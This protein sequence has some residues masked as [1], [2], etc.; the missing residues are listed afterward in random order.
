MGTLIQSSPDPA[1]NRWLNLAPEALIRIVWQGRRWL[2]W[3]TGS[4]VVMGIFVAL[5][6][7]PEFV[8]EARIMPELSTA[9]G[10]LF[11]RLAS[12]TGFAGL[13]L[14]DAEA[15]DAIRPDLY[16]N[17]LQSTPFLLDLIGRPVTT[18]EGHTTTVGR[19]L[20]PDDAAGWS[21]TRLFAFGR[22][23]AGQPKKTGKRRGPVELTA[24]Q[25]DLV[26]EIGKRVTARLDT[27][28]GIITIRAQMPDARVAALVAQYA[29]DYL[30][31][32]VTTYRTEKARQDLQFYTQRLTEARRRYQTAQYNVF[33]YNDQ[34]KYFV[35]QAATMDKQHLEA[36]LTIA[37]TVYT[38]LS[39]QFEQAKLEVQERTPVFKLLE[40]AQV[41]LKRVSP[42]R[43]LLVL[44]A[45]G[46]GLIF[47]VLYLLAQAANW[48]GRLRTMLEE[49]ANTET[50]YP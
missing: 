37:Q 2:L 49:P 29:M 22:R 19:F 28:S 9:S 47:G 12:A 32:Y 39:R 43:T 35:V 17:V 38:E 10:S 24:W 50:I 8:S 23:V 31:Q 16:P 25:Q 33:H 6:T 15:V 34:H 1:N 14:S 27:R 44:A 42:R 7:K 45:G 21:F 13:D 11:K 46:I 36:E 5:L 40:P 26:E 48:A 30:T 20:L 3:F 41:P 4:F 18:T